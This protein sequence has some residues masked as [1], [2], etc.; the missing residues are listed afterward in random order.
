MKKKGRGLV[1]V[2]ASGSP[3]RSVSTRRRRDGDFATDRFLEVDREA[4][5]LSFL[6]RSL[7]SENPSTTLPP[8]KNCS[9]EEAPA[10]LC[11]GGTPCAKAAAWAM[12]R[13]G[14]L[15]APVTDWKTS[16]IARF[17][18]KGDGREAAVR[19]EAPRTLRQR[20]CANFTM[21]KKKESLAK[22]R[23]NRFFCRSGTSKERS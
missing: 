1:A 2:R 20:N 11:A 4:R 15:R 17:S 13:G 3:E 7:L 5:T 23:R 18:S 16:F 12:P 14:V 6:V 10:G 19:S 21:R 8:Q 9:R 22:N